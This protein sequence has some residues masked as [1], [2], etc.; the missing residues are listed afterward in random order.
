MADPL[1]TFSTRVSGLWTRRHT[2][3][4]GEG[5]RLGVL[6]VRRN[7][8]GLINRADYTPEKG[9]ALTIRRDPGLLRAQFSVWT[10]G[11][12]WLG[13]SLRWSLSRR[14]VDM[15]TGGRPYRV[16]PTSGFGSGWRMVASKT[17]EAARVETSLLGRSSRWKV[18]RK[19]D[20]ELLL[21]AYFLGSMVHWE[22]FLPTALDHT[23]SAGPARA[24]SRA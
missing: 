11:K 6:T 23:G 17:G 16:V 20:F 24:T 2:L 14:Q 21:F 9:E 7:G 13:S 4:D 12:E 8:W 3:F 18:W 5:N 22:S 19:V 1:K 15:W 10:D